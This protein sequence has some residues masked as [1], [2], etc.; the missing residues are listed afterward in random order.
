M[1]QTLEFLTENCKEVFPSVPI[2][3]VLSFLRIF[4]AELTTK[5][6]LLVPHTQV[7]LLALL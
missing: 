5:L 2:H 6:D 1:D 3:L 7:L 4:K